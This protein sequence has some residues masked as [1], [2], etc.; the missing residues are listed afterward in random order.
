MLDTS[1]QRVKQTKPEL[2]NINT[3]Q[4]NS[5]V[6]GWLYAVKV[7]IRTAANRKT[8][9]QI[10]LRDQLGNE[11]IA[12]HFDTSRSDTLALQEGKVILLEGAVEE[13][14]NQLQM[15]LFRA[16]TDESV[17]L[18]IFTIGTRCAIAQL[19]TDFEHLI[20]KVDHRGLNKLLR[21]CFSSEVMERFRKWPAAMRNHG[22]VSGGLLEHT[23]NVA[24]IAEL[25]AH[26]YPCNH[27][28]VITGALLHDIGKLEELEEQVG[29]G[30]TPLGRMVGHIVLGMHYVQ[31]Q[32]HQIAELDE[33]LVDDVLHIILAHHTKELG[34]P[35]NPATLEALIVHKADA[36]E[37]QLTSFL[38]HCQR[39]AGLN[40][41]TT[42]SSVHGGQL[43]VP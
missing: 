29:A 11:I 18:D 12:R 22:A 10:T 37:A 4:V 43:R 6:F 13:Y 36:T 14:C 40:G 34:S 23:V 7:Q 1:L 2:L 9:L 28:L 26:L 24:S 30:Y 42:Y 15:K 39:T 3:L 5:T 27:D 25:I 41:W 21:C 33:T 38:E 19:E 32:A 17:P 20:D 31:V 35:V 8:Y 16:E